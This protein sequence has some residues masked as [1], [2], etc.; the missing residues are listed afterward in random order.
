MAQIPWSQR[1][2]IVADAGVGGAPILVQRRAPAESQIVTNNSSRVL[3]ILGSEAYLSSLER[4]PKAAAQ[5]VV[6]PLALRPRI[7][8]YCAGTKPSK[9]QASMPRSAAQVR[10]LPNRM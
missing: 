1:K 2:A 5:T 7:S 4:Y 3:R 6:N 9:G 8:S 10:R